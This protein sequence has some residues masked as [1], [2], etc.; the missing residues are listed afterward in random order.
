MGCIKLRVCND[1]Q[2]EHHLLFS[3]Q[4]GLTSLDN[5][6]IDDLTC[7]KCHGSNYSERH[8]RGPAP[9]DEV[10]DGRVMFP[11][12]DVNLGV[13]FESA[14]HKRRYLRENRIVEAEGEMSAHLEAEFSARQRANEQ[15]EREYKEYRAMC[16]A[17][18]DVRKLEARFNQ[19]ASRPGITPEEVEREF[20]GRR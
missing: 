17:D 1:C 7:P 18:P 3:E 9:R 8:T 11:Y 13:T 6:D 2:A 14:A 10:T 15:S 16:E 4:H 20:Y 12:D 19:I 5:A